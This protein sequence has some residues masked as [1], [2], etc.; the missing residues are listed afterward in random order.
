M[1]FGTYLA[2]VKSRLLQ[3][4]SKESQTSMQGKDDPFLVLS[5]IMAEYSSRMECERSKLD[6][7]VRDQESKTG[8]TLMGYIELTR[9]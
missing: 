4:F 6:L 8:A 5:A 1:I 9:H 7:S 3:V 2:E